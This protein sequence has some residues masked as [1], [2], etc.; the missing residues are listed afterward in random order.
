MCATQLACMKVLTH[1]NPGCRIRIRRKLRH[2]MLADDPSTITMD[3]VVVE[4]GAMAE[5]AAIAGA[6][7]IPGGAE[8]P[9]AVATEADEVAEGSPS[10]C[11][12]SRRQRRRPNPANCTWYFCFDIVNSNNSPSSSKIGRATHSSS[13]LFNAETNAS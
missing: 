3:A 11:T 8:M 6:V 2:A 9:G 1:L 4:V 10:S 7:E 13:R 5:D 12:A